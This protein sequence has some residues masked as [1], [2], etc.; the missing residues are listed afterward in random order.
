MATSNKS[1][2]DELIDFYNAVEE[3]V[4]ELFGSYDRAA[5]Y[6]DRRGSLDS[7]WEFAKDRYFEGWHASRVAK[8]WYGEN[9]GDVNAR[10]EP[11]FTRRRPMSSQQPPLAAGV[12]T[13]SQKFWP[14]AKLVA[15]SGKMPA[16]SS[17]RTHNY[18]FQCDWHSGEQA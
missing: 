9:V 5:A 14:A 18:R 12:M 8:T 10:G 11:A 1:N 2:H 7:L 16:L 3:R 13:S 6:F 17:N 4:I 15:S